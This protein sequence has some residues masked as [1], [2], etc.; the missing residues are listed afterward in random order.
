M[1]I[2]KRAANFMA[3]ETPDEVNGA[4]KKKKP[5][6]INQLDVYD[7]MKS[8]DSQLDSV[9]KWTTSP[10]NQLAILRRAQAVA[11]A[12]LHVQGVNGN[13]LPPNAISTRVSNVINYVML[14]LSDIEKSRMKIGAAYLWMNPDNTVELVPWDEVRGSNFIV[15]STT[16]EYGTWNR[17]RYG[18]DTRILD[19]TTCM[20]LG[21]DGDLP[22]E[23][24][25]LRPLK[26]ISR[27]YDGADA[28]FE[29]TIHGLQAIMNFKDLTDDEL[30]QIQ[31][32]VDEHFGIDGGVTNVLTVSTKEGALDV[33]PIRRASVEIPFIETFKLAIEEVGRAYDET[34]IMLFENTQSIYNN[35]RLARIDFNT[36]TTTNQLVRICNDLTKE[37]VAKAGLA[38]GRRVWFDLSRSVGTQPTLD[39]IAGFAQQLCGRPVMTPN[40]FN[41]MVGLPDV[42]GGDVIST[43]YTTQTISISATQNDQEQFGARLSNYVKDKVNPDDVISKELYALNDIYDINETKENLVRTNK[44]LASGDVDVMML[45]RLVHLDALDNNGVTKFGFVTNISEDE[46]PAGLGCIK[47]GNKATFGMERYLKNSCRCLLTAK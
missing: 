45:A 21:S 38:R 17:S 47:R 5:V 36:N 8:Y 25:A 12:T 30:E 28:T 37:L 32:S 6:S 29:T 16:T 14:N 42:E 11:A 39:E 33:T 44:Y 7:I 27:I 1:N 19:E 35:A 15:S 4:A 3:R 46:C 9:R 24:V 34:P 13:T 22:A 10:V 40:T 2:F 18:D 43:E 20:R 26:L 23:V 31:G 41:N